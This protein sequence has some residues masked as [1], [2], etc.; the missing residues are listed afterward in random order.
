MNKKNRL[1]PGELFVTPAPHIYHKDS[2]SKIMWI[3][4]LSL[5]PAGVWSVFLF[6]IPALNIII[7]T[8][9]TCLLTE[10]GFNLIR[11]G[12]ITIG[13]GSAALTGML[14]AFILPP[15]A[16]LY[17]PITASLFAI[18][19]VK[20]LFGG[21]GYN[22]LNPALAGRVFVMFSWL[23]PM[24]SSQYYLPRLTESFLP[25]AGVSLEATSSATALFTIKNTPGNLEGKLPDLW[26]LFLGKIGGSLGEVS[27]LLLLL[28]ALWLLKRRYITWQIPLSFVGS[29]F[30]FSFIYGYFT[31]ASLT[32]GYSSWQNAICYALAHILSGGLIL[33]A[34]FMTTDMVTTPLTVRGQFI[35]GLGAGA[36]TFIIRVFG[37]YPEGVMFAILLMNIVT[38][39]IDRQS[40][41]KIYGWGNN[42]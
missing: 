40:R 32:A 9:V 33:G 20:H 3:V 27:A 37:G 16:P 1:N 13:D 42:P 25:D 19:V 36:L 41:P 29:L 7:T 12:P 24:T 14:L 34:F 39:L 30:V 18:G 35:A 5:L 8:L 17:I 4:F 28:G 15:Y 38:P 26:D 31:H 22:V 10:A 21:L 6:G 2:T 23:E 11:K